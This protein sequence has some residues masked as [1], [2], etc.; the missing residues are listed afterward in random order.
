VDKEAT[1]GAQMTNMPRMGDYTK[2]FGE[3]T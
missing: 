2:V 1:R 3:E